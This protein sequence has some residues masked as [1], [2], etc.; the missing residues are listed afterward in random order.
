[1]HTTPE[2]HL[3]GAVEVNIEKL[4]T[5]AILAGTVLSS[6]S[7]SL[8]EHQKVIEKGSSQISK[9]DLFLPKNVHTN[10]MKSFSNAQENYHSPVNLSN[11]VF[12]CDQTRGTY[13]VEKVRFFL[14]HIGGILGQNI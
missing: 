10:K 7:T 12:H 3:H 9:N 13:F 5:E 11:D 1:M 4:V 8:N 6:S 14:R 2:K